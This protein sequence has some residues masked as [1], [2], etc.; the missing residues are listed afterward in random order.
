M[1]RVD[2]LKPTQD[3]KEYIEK[4]KRGEVDMA[5]VKQFLDKRKIICN[6]QVVGSSPIASSIG[7]ARLPRKTSEAF[8]VMN[9]C[10]YAPL[11]VLIV[12]D[13]DLN[14]IALTII[15]LPN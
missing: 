3:F 2:G 7:T 13:R 4:E 8:F 9:F 14:N 5:D 6:E 15:F 11:F 10:L 1:I 12:F